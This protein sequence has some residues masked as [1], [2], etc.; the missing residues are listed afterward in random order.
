MIFL[1]LPRVEPQTIILQRF[2]IP[3]SILQAILQVLIIKL[4][5]SWGGV[6]IHAP[7]SH[8]F[9]SVVSSR[10]TEFPK[11]LGIFRGKPSWY[12][13]DSSILVEGKIE[14]TW[15]LWR[16]IGREEGGRDGQTKFHGGCLLEIGLDFVNLITALSKICNSLRI[17]TTN[18]P[19]P[20]D[21]ISLNWID[22]FKR[23]NKIGKKRRQFLFLFR[24]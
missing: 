14:R 23:S 8:L 21:W 18:F 1:Y 16:E 20:L 22:T 4:E 19:P 24:C 6:E 9:N 13:D 10:D 17:L 2:L 5:K 3:L 7:R 11:S 12:F 15:T